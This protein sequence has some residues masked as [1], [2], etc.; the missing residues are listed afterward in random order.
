MHN[1][2]F[3]FVTVMGEFENVTS[4]N[5]SLKPHG[6]PDLNYL[7]WSKIHD[8]QLHTTN[9]LVSQIGDKSGQ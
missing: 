3:G 8:Q 2:T 1:E 5:M 6:T 4:A 9:K 7:L